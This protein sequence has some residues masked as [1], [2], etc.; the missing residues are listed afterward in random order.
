M[1][2]QDKDNPY[3]FPKCKECDRLAI[4]LIDSQGPGKEHDGL[5]LECSTKEDVND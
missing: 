2:V 3:G 1:A 4:I 5:C